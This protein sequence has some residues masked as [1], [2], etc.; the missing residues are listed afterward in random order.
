MQV[1]TWVTL[2][3]L[4]VQ[5]LFF[6]SPVLPLPASIPVT[7]AFFGVSFACVYYGYLAT[8]TDP[9]DKHLTCALRRQQQ[10]SEQQTNSNPSQPTGFLALFYTAGAEQK[11]PPEGETTKY[12]WVCETDVAEHAMHCKYCN[13]CISQFDHHCK[14]LNTCVGESNYPYF[15]RTLISISSLLLVHL[16]VMVGIVADIFSGGPTEQLAKDWFGVGTPYVVVCFNIVFCVFSSIAFMLIVQ[17]LVFH[18]GLQRKGLTTYKYILRDNQKKRDK[19]KQE[20]AWN[21]K[22]AVAI[23]KA[24]TE[25]KSTFMLKLGKYMACLDPLRN[26]DEDAAQRQDKQ[27]K[28]A[29]AKTT[30]AE[31]EKDIEQGS[32]IKNPVA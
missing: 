29:P 31:D 10:D 19:Q 13:K 22:R 16:G 21:A 18:V 20:Q 3:T 25:K 6:C 4:M 8:A 1:A 24:K 12:C 5:F 2:P 14:W 26:S 27:E 15:F 30:T 17:L 23:K 11:P 32:E 7:V 9:M 28:D